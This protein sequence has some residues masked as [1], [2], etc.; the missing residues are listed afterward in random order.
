MPGGRH[1]G[2]WRGAKF[3]VVESE[4]KGHLGAW[5]RWELGPFSSTGGSPRI[6]LLPFYHGFIMLIMSVFSGAIRG[7]E[8]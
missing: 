3:E 1:S 4:S 2:E 7:E 6:K 8:A 5:P